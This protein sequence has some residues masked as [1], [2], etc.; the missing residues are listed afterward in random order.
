MAIVIVLLLCLLANVLGKSSKMHLC[1]LQLNLQYCNNLNVII[2]VLVC[3]V[4]MYRM[5]VTEPIHLEM[6]HIAGC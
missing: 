1:L 2:A 5:I 4:I 6:Y 3:Q